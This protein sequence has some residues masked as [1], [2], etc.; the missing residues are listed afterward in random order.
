MTHNLEENQSIEMDPKM[1]ELMELPE[2][3][4]KIAIVNMF[5]YI[6][7]YIMRREIEN[8][9]KNVNGNLQVKI[10]NV[11]EEKLTAWD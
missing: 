5:T 4:I 9:K 2:K 1:T 10:F 7:G 3:Y 6:K 8:T 11:W